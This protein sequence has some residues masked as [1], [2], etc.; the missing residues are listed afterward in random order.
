MILQ[1]IPA[2]AL[3]DA[4]AFDGMAFDV[5]AFDGMAFDA[6]HRWI[7]IAACLD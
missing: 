5:M 2:S 3:G 7:G 4:G 6:S 1:R